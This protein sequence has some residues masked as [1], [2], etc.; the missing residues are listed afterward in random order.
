MGLEE[1]RKKYD[2]PEPFYLPLGKNVLIWRIEGEEKTAGG[3][4]VPEEH[5]EVKTRGVLIA[6]GLAALDVLADN[7]I[8]VGDEVVFAK[9]AGRD[10]EA[11]ERKQ[12]EKTT[13]ILECKVEDVLGSVDALVRVKNYDAKRDGETGE[14]FYARKG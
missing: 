13:K 11:P 4:Y 12:G 5:R 1:K 14:H 6:A 7:L 9:Y 8:A 2:I 10:R 3:L